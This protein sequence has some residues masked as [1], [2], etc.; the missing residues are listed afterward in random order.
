MFETRKIKKTTTWALKERLLL[1]RMSGRIRIIEAP[2]VPIM[3]AIMVP[4]A[5]I[6]VLTGAE[7]LSLPS[8]ETPP[9]AVNSAKRQIFE[10][11][12]M[13]EPRVRRRQP[14]DGDKASEREDRPKPSGLGV[15]DM[16][17]FLDRERAK[18]DRQQYPGEGQGERPGSRA[19]SRPSPA[20]A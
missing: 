20:M 1:A 10:R 4:S 16:P 7:P 18:R 8:I 13:H 6:V 5:R 19:P 2:V 12:A 15:M 14:F 11:H 3:L 9:A 17:P